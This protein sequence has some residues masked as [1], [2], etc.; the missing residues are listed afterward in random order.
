MKGLVI[1]APASGHGKTTVTLGLLAAWRQAGI[2]VVS[3]KSGPDYIDPAFHAAASG[4]ACATLDSWAMDPGTLRARLPCGELLVV[5]GAMGMFDAAAG[6][7]PGGAGSVAALARALG[8]PVVLVVDA[9]RMGQSIRALVDGFVRAGGGAVAGVILNRVGSP[10]HRAMLVAALDGMVPVL[11]ILPRAEGLQTPSRHLGLVQA[12]ERPDLEAFIG[13]AAK[14]VSQGCDLNALSALAQGPLP[15]EAGPLC[16]PPLGQR[17]AVAQDLAFSFSYPHML[18]DWRAAGAEVATFSPLADESPPLTADAVFLPGGYPE[19][20]AGRLSGASRFLEG[21]R[22]AAARGAVIYGECGGY[23]VL[24][25]GLIDADGTRHAMAGLLTLETSFAERSRHLGYRKLVAGS[26]PLAGA[27][28]GHEFHYATT[29]SAVGIP[30][31][32]AED[33]E[34]ATLPPMGLRDG[35]VMGSFAHLISCAPD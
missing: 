15:A 5:E 24:G 11:G 18:D 16:L 25:D 12:G 14:W 28:R 2:R 23:M 35:C 19:L 10:R 33:A 20:H 26:G 3:A 6:A 27:Y 7:R 29:L 32:A 9:A 8:L 22:A 34:G 21:L 30:L 31:F 1:A 4:Q 13:D 17:I